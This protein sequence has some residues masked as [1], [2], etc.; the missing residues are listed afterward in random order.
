MFECIEV[1]KLDPK[2]S[3]I[4]WRAT[5]THNEGSDIIRLV[6]DEDPAK[7]AHTFVSRFMAKRDTVFNVP[8]NQMRIIKDFCEEAAMAATIFK[9]KG[10]SPDLVDLLPTTVLDFQYPEKTTFR[11]SRAARINLF[12]EEAMESLG[13]RNFE[14]A[15]QRL[16]WV[17]HL[18]PAHEFAFQMKVVTLRNW[19]KMAECIPV[20]EAWVRTYPRDSEPRLGLGEMWLFLGQNQKAHDV[21][22][23]MLRLEPNQPMALVGQAQAKARLGEDPSPIIRKAWMLDRDYTVAMVEERFDF[24]MPKPDDLEPATIKDISSRYQIPLKRTLARAAAGTLPMHP[25][26]DETGLLRFS[27]KELDRHYNVLRALGLELV[28][29]KRE[30]PQPVQP[31]LFDEID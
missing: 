28:A 5:D 27:K 8:D 1:H 16:N 4:E 30:E 6:L 21:F 7:M 25:A 23:D 18:D 29:I 26:S 17:H 11:K 24:R 13:Q 15:M 20:L 3:W 19:R 2:F 12:C 22:A 9:N 31:G 14:A 10:E